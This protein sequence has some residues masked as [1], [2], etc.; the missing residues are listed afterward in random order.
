VNAVV[1][2]SPAERRALLWCLGVGAYA[3][4]VGT[5]QLRDSF[6]SQWAARSGLSFW[7][8]AGIAVVDAVLVVTGSRGSHAFRTLT[9]LV[10][11]FVFSMA[12]LFGIVGA[13]VMLLMAYPSFSGPELSWSELLLGELIFVPTGA[14]QLVSLRAVPATA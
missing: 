10:V 8:L 3:V 6:L 9:R 1:R 7:E 2:R 14:V 5:I 4:V 12:V 13:V 11:W